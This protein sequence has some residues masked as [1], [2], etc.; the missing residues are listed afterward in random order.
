MIDTAVKDGKNLFSELTLTQLSHF[1]E[2]SHDFGLTV[3]LAGSLRKEDLPRAHALGADVVG[4]R[5]AACTD[6]DR[7]NGR[8]KKENVRELFET[9]KL[10]EENS[11]SPPLASIGR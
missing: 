6:G 3:A 9:I 8:I 10:L 5:G 4:L 2:M 7:I 1:T 11:I